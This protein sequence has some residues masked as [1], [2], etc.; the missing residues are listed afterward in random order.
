MGPD[1]ATYGDVAIRSGA[2]RLIYGNR[3][4]NS[5]EYYTQVSSR[6]RPSGYN[7][8]IVMLPLES[9]HYNC[10]GTDNCYFP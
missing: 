2:D 3:L 10:Y 6:F 7:Q 4:D 5:N 9:S 1:P 8:D